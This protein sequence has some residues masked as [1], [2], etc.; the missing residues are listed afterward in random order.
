MDRFAFRLNF[1]V[2]VVANDPDG[3]VMLDLLFPAFA[4]PASFLVVLPFLVLLPRLIYM[5]G[6]KLSYYRAIISSLAASKKSMSVG[7]IPAS[8]MPAVSYS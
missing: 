4:L 2:D 1:A 3:A 5:L 8:A 6:C 7:V